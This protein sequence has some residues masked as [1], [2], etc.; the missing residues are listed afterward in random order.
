MGRTR[1]V[2]VC[3]RYS[4]CP[5]PARTCARVTRDPSGLDLGDSKSDAAP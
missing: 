2:R 5:A 1:K 3:P 4:A